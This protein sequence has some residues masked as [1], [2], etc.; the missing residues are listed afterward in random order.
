MPVMDVTALAPGQ[1]QHSVELFDSLCYKSMLPLHEIDKDPVRKELDSRFACEVLG[2]PNAILQ[3]DGPMDLLR[4]KLAQE[5]S[6]RG[7]K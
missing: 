2:L 3:P 1:L 7:N 5:P 6:I 4:R